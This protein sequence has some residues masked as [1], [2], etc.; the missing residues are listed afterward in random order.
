MDYAFFTVPAAVPAVAE[1]G[2]V[3]TVGIDVA[4]GV[5][6]AAML[7]ALAITSA[8]ER[9][10]RDTISAVIA[11]EASSAPSSLPSSS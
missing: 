5:Y 10:E 2:A 8:S 6:C 4:E 1:V 3:A 7:A 9:V 11:A